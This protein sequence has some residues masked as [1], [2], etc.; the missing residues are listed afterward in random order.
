SGELKRRMT[1][2]PSGAM[3]HAAIFHA[4]EAGVQ[5]LTAI[6]GVESASSMSPAD[7]DRMEARP[8]VFFTGSETFMKNHALSEEL[9]G[10]STVVV[11]CNSRDDLLEMA[12]TL[13]GHL[14]ATIHG[15][16][17]DLSDYAA[18]ISILE[19]KVGRLIFNGFPT[20]VELCA[21][22]EHGGPYPAT[23]DS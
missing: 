21:A 1:S 14:T 13:K 8:S 15:N 19:E 20:G 10:P 7:Q 11:R 3:L 4:Y 12:A 2:S 6:E 9:F 17:K 22:M 16:S 23:T 5:R 18:L